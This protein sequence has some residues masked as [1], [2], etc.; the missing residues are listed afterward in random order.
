MTT[1]YRELVENTI[2]ITEKLQLFLHNSGIE[3]AEKQMGFSAFSLFL[4]EQGV[5][6]YELEAFSKDLSRIVANREA[7]E[8]IGKSIQGEDYKLPSIPNTQLK[9]IMLYTTWLEAQ[10]TI[11]EIKYRMKI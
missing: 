11:A 3:L 9:W 4:L 8:D 2:N 10:L 7:I 6:P 5:Q 1:T